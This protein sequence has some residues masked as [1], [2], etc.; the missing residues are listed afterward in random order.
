[1]WKSVTTHSSLSLSSPLDKQGCILYLLVL[2]NFFL[3]WLINCCL[4]QLPKTQKGNCKNH[5]IRNFFIPLC[6]CCYY[7]NYYSLQVHNFLRLSH[8]GCILPEIFRFLFQGFPRN[9]HVNFSKAY[10]FMR[11]LIHKTWQHD[12]EL[13]HLRWG[14]SRFRVPNEGRRMISSGVFWKCLTQC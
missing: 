3:Q 12:C 6:S 7:Y 10:E 14:L 9:S 5:C 4:Q 8:E 2:Q 11:E 1:M 13:P